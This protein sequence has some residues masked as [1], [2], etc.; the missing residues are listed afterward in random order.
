MTIDIGIGLLI[1]AAL[2]AGALYIMY[3]FLRGW[4]R[5]K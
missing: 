4:G 5:R 2:A 1:G 3:L